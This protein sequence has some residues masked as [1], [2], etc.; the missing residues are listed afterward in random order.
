MGALKGIGHV[1]VVKGGSDALAREVDELIAPSLEKI[2]ARMAPSTVLGGE[3]TNTFGDDTTDEIVEELVA[4]I[5]AAMMESDHVED[6]FA[7]DHVIRRDVFRVLRT[8]L[9]RAHEAL[10]DSAQ[11]PLVIRLDTL[12]YVAATAAKHADDVVLRDALNRA[13]EVVSAELIDYD[14]TE[15]QVTF[16]P[17]PEA[18]PD[19][20]IELE[21]AIADELTGL[22]DSGLVELPGVE[23]RVPLSARSG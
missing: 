15:R 23:R 11:D 19:A 20:R 18:G 6:V 8:E 5:A 10:V 14:A 2:L 12:G 1:L 17:S 4:E 13:A 16:E 21:E 9:W 22:V 3:V 7:E